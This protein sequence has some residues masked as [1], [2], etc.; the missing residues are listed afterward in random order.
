MLEGEM[1]PHT[2]K[3]L[4]ERRSLLER[5]ADPILARI[6]RDRERAPA[7]IRPLLAYLES[8]LFDPALDGTRLKQACG[9]RD[10]TLPISFH[11]ALSLPPY[12][13]IENCRME[14][15]C[16]LLRG[17]QLKVWQIAQQLGYSTLQVFSRAFRRWAGVRPSVFRSQN[18]PEA[19]EDEEERRSAAISMVTLVKAVEGSLEKHE[20]D[21]LSRHL[22][23]LYP[24]SF[25]PCTAELQIVG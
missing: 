21:E 13:Y 16:R 19:L 18:P 24:E 10:N 1:R 3:S 7:Q 12:A 15:A 22:A 14:V 9:V 11:K 20:A 4:L 5:A 6:R 8:H 17:S 2:M 23:N 25:R